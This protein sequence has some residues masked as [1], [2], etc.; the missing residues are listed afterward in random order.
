MWEQ[1]QQ[2]VNMCTSIVWVLI[3]VSYGSC[4]VACTLGNYCCMRGMKK[5][6]ERYELFAMQQHKRFAEFGPIKARPENRV[7]KIVRTKKRIR[8]KN[9]QEYRNTFDDTGRMRM[10]HHTLQDRSRLI[11]IRERFF[12]KFQSFEIIGDMYRY[13]EAFCYYSWNAPE[14][15]ISSSLTFQNLEKKTQENMEDWKIARKQCRK[16]GKKSS[17][18]RMTLRGQDFAEISRR[19]GSARDACGR[20]GRIRGSGRG[21]RGWCAPRRRDRA[22]RP[23]AAGEIHKGKFSR[24]R[25][26]TDYRSR[27]LQ[28]FTGVWGIGQRRD[29]FSCSPHYCRYDY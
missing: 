19:G 17:P 20:R 3:F 27:R 7:L 4:V 11:L 22:E 5:N 25:S 2:Q 14:A 18:I 10:N 13:T 1:Q 29:C 12:Q 24:W 9:Q 8:E 6:R 28:A 26:T 16:F 15:K 23:S 21:T